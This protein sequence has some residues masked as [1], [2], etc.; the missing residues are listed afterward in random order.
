VTPSTAYLAK[1]VRAL[2]EARIFF[3]HGHAEG[4]CNRAYYA[5]F[6]AAHGALWAKGIEGADNVVKTHNGLVALFGKSLVQ[7]G[8][9]AASLGKA[10]NTVQ[11]FRQIADYQGD[12]PSLE[13]TAEALRLAEVFVAE[14][15][16]AFFD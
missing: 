12:P 1:A 4:A 15:K 14:I 8:Q 2:E 3:A 13:D 7:T 5:M 6:D 11:N 9:V 10:L 16:S